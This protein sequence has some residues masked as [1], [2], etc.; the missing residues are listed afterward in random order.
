MEFSVY[1]QNPKLCVVQA[2]NCYL[3]VLQKWRDKNGQKQLLLSTSE[4][5]QEVQKSSVADWI[6]TLLRLVGVDT[7]L[8]NAH[9]TRSASTSKTEVKGLTTEDILQRGKLV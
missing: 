1:P 8:F 9:S 6:K 7:S 2:I 3:Q 5:H 4:P